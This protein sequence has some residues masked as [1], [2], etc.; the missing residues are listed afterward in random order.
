MAYDVDQA[1]LKLEPPVRARSKASDSLSVHR[2][3]S[4]FGTSKLNE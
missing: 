4:S 2:I 3:T 1:R